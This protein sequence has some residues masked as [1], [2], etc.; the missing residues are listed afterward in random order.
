MKQKTEKF[1][2]SILQTKV[3]RSKALANL[4]IS[5]A[6]QVAA[7][8]VTSL[9]LNPCYHYQ[10]SSIRDAINFL[11]E[12]KKESVAS[13]DE[14]KCKKMEKKESIASLDE[15]K[16]KK[17]EKKL[18]AIK[19]P[20]FPKPHLGYYLLNTD[21]TPILRPH[22]P[23]LEDRSYVHVS[24][25]RV[26]GKTPV[27]IGY[28]YSCVG[29]SAR[30]S[31]TYGEAPWNLPLS[32]RRFTTTNTV[33]LATAEQVNDLLDNPKIPL[34]KELVVNSLDRQ[35]CTPEYIANTHE[36]EN[37][38][39]IVRLKNNRATWHQLSEEDVADRREKNKDNRGANAV[40]GEK[41]SLKTV[42]E[43][44]VKA[45]EETQFDTQLANGRLVTVK[46]ECWKNRLIRTKRGHNM[47]NKSFNL[48]SIILLDRETKEPIYKR[49]LWL[50]V[51]GKRNNKLDLKQIYWAYRR[52]F[53]IEH[54]FRFGK[55]RL[56]MEAC[57][58]PDI[59]HLDNWMEIVSL[60]YWLLWVAK[61]E[62]EPM[63][64]KW[65]QYDDR[66][67]ARL[68]KGLTPSPSEVQRQLQSIILSFEQTP[69][70]PKV[71]KKGKG[72]DKGTE[73]AKRKTYK[74]V[75]KG[76]KRKKSTIKT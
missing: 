22:S 60:A 71:Q 4:V 62:A 73:Q 40:Y 59:E 37:L 58:T 2:H 74:V 54:Y 47:K 1:C 24:N 55:Q 29:L 34:H 16:R 15:A 75:Y 46:M 44:N 70:K 45:N 7:S 26:K 3:G 10:Y 41:Y 30:F 67:K 23:T 66:F 8:S 14:A 33:G 5:L 35:Y 63:A 61:D 50:G 12:E 56:L 21:I 25:N 13:L 52:R 49:R 57:Q 11:H 64:Y 43:W 19:A 6:S 9:S 53:D 68:E 32:I 76:S 69:F 39:N 51:W 72:R 31:N 27:D 48:V 18:L 65:Q 20:H 17:M 28:N 36:Q 38:I 42:E